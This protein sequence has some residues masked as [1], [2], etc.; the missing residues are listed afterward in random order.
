MEFNSD[1][2]EVMQFEKLHSGRARTINS[3]AVRTVVTQ[4]DLIYNSLKMV[5]QVDKIIKVLNST[6][7]FIGW[8]IECKS[9]ATDYFMSGALVRPQLE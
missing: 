6:I 2:C 3:K 5:T 8:S 9:L 7:A 4:R 1:T